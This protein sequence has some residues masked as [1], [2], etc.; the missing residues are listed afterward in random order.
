MK[1]LFWK[2]LYLNEMK[3]S[4]NRKIICKYHSEYISTVKK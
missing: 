1:N 3:P 2:I 4:K